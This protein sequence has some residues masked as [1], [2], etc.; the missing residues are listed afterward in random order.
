MNASMVIQDD[1]V[2]QPR[3]A[4]RRARRV[5]ML[6]IAIALLGVVDLYA[7]YVHATTI[8]MMELNPIGAYIISGDSP[9]GLIL[10]KLGS[11]GLCVGLLM[12]LR[13][14]R[15]AELA[16]WLCLIIMIGLTLHWVQYNQ[17][18]FTL[19]AMNDYEPVDG[20]M[21]LSTAEAPEP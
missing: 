9:L 2:A 3:V 13:H 20:M 19:M 8:G 15:R 11:I 21:R 6:L 16:A 7:T 12:K 5:M 1:S 14:D 18:L 10:F 4:C 17:E